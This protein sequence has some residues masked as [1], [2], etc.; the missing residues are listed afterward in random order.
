MI[1]TA[2]PVAAMAILENDI[3]HKSTKIEDAKKY[4]PYIYYVGQKNI[5]LSYW[6]FFMCIKSA[7]LHA[8][9]CMY[10]CYITFDVGPAKYG[11]QNSDF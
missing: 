1:F 7:I 9:V 4:I 3:N 5:I 8:L 11:G 6:E 2:F 10:V